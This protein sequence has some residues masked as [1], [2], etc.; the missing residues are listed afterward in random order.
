MSGKSVKPYITGAEKNSLPSVD[1]PNEE[2]QIDFIGPITENHR[3]FYIL[4]SMD[5]FS[6]RP[7]ACF[8][9]YTDRETMVKFL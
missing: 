6:E 4:L 7:A 8:C 5:R 9:K 2:I 1:S 3:R